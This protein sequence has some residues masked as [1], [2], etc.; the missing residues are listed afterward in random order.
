MNKIFCFIFT[1]VCFS[2]HALEVDFVSSFD[3]NELPSKLNN[4]KQEFK[5]NLTCPMDYVKRSANDPNLKKIIVFDP[6]YGNGPNVFPTLP[7]EK[8]VLFVW[9]PVILPSHI[10][11]TYSRVYTW[12]DTLVDNVKFFR[13]NYPYLMPN[14]E[15]P[16]PFNK[17]KMC[18]L[19]VGNW[20]KERLN[21]VNFFDKNHPQDL[22]CYG[23]FPPGLK[24]SFMHKGHIA[25]LHS[26]EE[27][28][29]TLQNY[30]FCICFE[31]TVGLQGYITEKI[32]S[33]FAAGCIPIYWGPS[34]IEN[35]IPKSC[36]IDYR[37]FSSVA[38]LYDFISS[39]SK[40]RHQKY[41]NAIK[42]Y[43]QSENAKIFSP[44]YFENLISEA[45]HY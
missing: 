5:V 9:E 38:E 30:R 10:Y 1:A 27:K 19:V 24:N 21:V 11:E 8:L 29:R 36:F 13:F 3:I 45:I 6:T 41:I 26:G 34:N 22:E 33:C 37:D 32:F 18:T 20:T 39:M 35:Y 44:E 25:G 31:N 16:I 14:K 43:L 42:H 7:K 28:I 12:D 40:E 4:I 15:N 2:T 23:R 17:R